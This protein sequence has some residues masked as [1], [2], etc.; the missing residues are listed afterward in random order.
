MTTLCDDVGMGRRK[1]FRLCILSPCGSYPDIRFRTDSS[2]YV[3]DK[4][5]VY[6]V[7]EHEPPNEY[8][9]SEIGWNDIGEIRLW[10][11]LALSIREGEGFF[12]FVPN[13]EEYGRT[14]TVLY[15][16]RLRE[17]LIDKV[18]SRTVAGAGDRSYKLHWIGPRLAEVRRLYDALQRA[19]TSSLRGLNCFLKALAIWSLPRASGLLTEEIGFNLYIALEGGLA[20]IRKGLSAS[21]GCMVSYSEVLNFVAQNFTYG[22]ALANY[23]EEAHDD[24][25]ALLH[26]DNPDAPYVIHPMSVDDIWE[27]FDPMLS[28][29]RFILLGEPRPQFDAHGRPTPRSPD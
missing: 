4:T 20:E 28:L 22:E 7:V 9:W 25:N 29:Y 21:A 6:S 16:E 17:D 23:W 3:A 2:L 8:G 27:L 24:R 15:L 26:P 5:L 10:G 1:K 13:L 18:V 19:S 14:P 11:A 12:A